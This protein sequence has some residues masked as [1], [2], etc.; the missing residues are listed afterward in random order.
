MTYLDYALIVV[1]AGSA[2]VGLFRGL[3]REAM[4]LAVWVAAL[5]AAGRYSG[6]LVPYMARWIESPV[7][8]LWA[9]RLAVLIAVL[10][11]GG[12]LTWLVSMAIRG[13]RLGG[14]DRSAGMAFGIARGVLLAAVLLVLL[15]VAG[16]DEEPWWRRSKLVPYATP[17][18][19][20]LREAAEREIGQ[21]GSLA[22]PLSGGRIPGRIGT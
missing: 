21:P 2:A 19:D 16:L 5:W 17:V 9:A 7:L 13:G 11:L 10:L 18:A 22:A 1:V 8:D 3:F 12:V 20:A 6:W 15:R 14:V 4:S